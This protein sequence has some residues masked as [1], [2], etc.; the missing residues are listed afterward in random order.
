[1]CQNKD[2]MSNAFKLQDKVYKLGQFRQSNMLNTPG[3]SSLG[4]PGVPWHTQILADQLTLFQVGGTNYAHLI[5]TV[6][7]SHPDFHI[8]RRP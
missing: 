8:F 1:M 5:T 4:V 7:L 2:R 6:T 3:L